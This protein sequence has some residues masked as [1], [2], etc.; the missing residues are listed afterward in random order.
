MKPLVSTSL[1]LLGTTLL[2][3][4]QVTLRSCSLHCDNSTGISNVYLQGQRGKKGPKGEKGDACECVDVTE[5]SEKYEKL[6]RALLSR[7]CK[8]VLPRYD[9]EEGGV[10]NIFPFNGRS[11][12]DVY[13]DHVTDGGGWLVF[14]KRIDG[15]E[16]FYRGWND[17]VN[18]FGKLDG[19]FWLG[20]EVLHQLT[21]NGS[22]QLRVDMEDFDGET[23]YVTYRNFVVGPGGGYNL[24]V[25]GF[26]GNTGSALNS[27]VSFSTHD[28]DQ[29]LYGANC[30]ERFKGAWW[31]TA[32]HSANPNGHYYGGAHESYADGVNWSSF[33]GY[34]YSLKRIDMKLRKN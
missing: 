23:K 24:T 28:R 21:K 5:L 1:F 10:Y 14:Q 4:C 7:S 8:D 18:G 19:E 16:D 29:D 13:C 6:K 32:C 33:R 25:S 12:I 22:Y 34:H 30:A 17:Y 20:L 27:G 2:V 26:K 15:S 11:G 31:Y 9:D 3:E